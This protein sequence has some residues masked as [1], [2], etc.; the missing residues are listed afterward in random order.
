MKRRRSE[1]LGWIAFAAVPVVVVLGLFAPLAVQG[2]VADVLS[3]HAAAEPVDPDMHLCKPGHPA[4]AI[5]TIKGLKDNKG[6]LILEVYPDN[7]KDFLKNR[8]GRTDSPIPEGTDPTLCVELPGPGRYAIVVHH[9]RDA[10][11]KFD[12]FKDGYGFS[13][14][15]HIA[16]S[17]PSVD[18]VAIDAKGRVTHLT[19]D[20]HYFFSSGARPPQR[21]LKK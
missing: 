5:V 11:N 13:N 16:F 14:N 2:S 1:T 8:L 3:P 21:G 12:L 15:P 17:T 18:D 10:D 19:I 9:D 20:V 6:D 4:Y 7:E